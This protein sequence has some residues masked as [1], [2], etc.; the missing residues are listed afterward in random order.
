MYTVCDVGQSPGCIAIFRSSR[1]GTSNLGVSSFTH[2]K[3]RLIE[4]SRETEMLPLVEYLIL[5]AESV[6]AWSGGWLVSLN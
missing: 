1:G 2:G 3:E 5:E 6:P 4:A